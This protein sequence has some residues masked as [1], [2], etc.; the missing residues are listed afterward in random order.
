[1]KKIKSILI[2]IT[3]ELVSLIVG[4][5]LLWLN[6]YGELSFGT[7]DWAIWNKRGLYFLSLVFISFGA[8]L[9]LNS[10]EKRFGRRR[11]GFFIVSLFALTVVSLLIGGQIG[12]FDAYSSGGAIN[13][14]KSWIAFDATTSSELYSLGVNITMIADSIATIVPIIMIVLGTIQLYYAGEA[15]EYLKAILEIAVVM[16]SLVVYGMFVAPVF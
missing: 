15:D 6:F 14:N 13:W 7:Q 2:E 8:S 16:G 5:W 11:W 9:V 1:M 10:K 4:I 3:V 12:L